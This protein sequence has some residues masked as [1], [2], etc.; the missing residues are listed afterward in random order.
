MVEV[1]PTTATIDF[2]TIVNEVIQH[3]AA[4]SGTQ[5]TITVEVEARSTQGF[6]ASF[7]RTINENCAVLKFRK[8][9]F[10]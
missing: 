2:S 7:Q 10:D 9:S 1:E 6:D 5:V 8:P 3:F 4:Q